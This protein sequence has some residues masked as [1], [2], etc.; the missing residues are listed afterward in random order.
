MATAAATPLPA[1]ED[2]LEWERRQESRWEL[3]D[4]L[5]LARVGGTADH[6]TIVHNLVAAA[7]GHAPRAVPGASPSLATSNHTKL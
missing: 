7:V 4:G 5:A 3:V 6:N 2:F 1:L